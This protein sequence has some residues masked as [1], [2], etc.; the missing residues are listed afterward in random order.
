MDLSLTAN[1][2]HY[3]YLSVFIIGN[4]LSKTNS[5]M[6]EITYYNKINKGMSL[7]GRARG[8]PPATMN[9][10]PSYFRRKEKKNRTTRNS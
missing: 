8:F 4:F 9:V 2:L 10:V 1:F 7:R 3:H 5:E 6:F